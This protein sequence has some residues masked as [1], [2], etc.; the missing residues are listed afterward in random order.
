M[1]SPTDSDP[2]VFYSRGDPARIRRTLSKTLNEY[3]DVIGTLSDELADH[4]AVDVRQP[5]ITAGVAV[6]EALVVEAQKV[7]DGGV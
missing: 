7:Q 6:G 5:E 3:L 4:P 1:R 2:Q